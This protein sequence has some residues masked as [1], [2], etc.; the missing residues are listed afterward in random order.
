[1]G[2]WFSVGDRWQRAKWTNQKSIDDFFLRNIVVL[3]IWKF[4]SFL[5]LAFLLHY[6]RRVSVINGRVKHNVFMSSCSS[7]N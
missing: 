2:C 6:P 5:E 7:F 4:V 1:M 3:D